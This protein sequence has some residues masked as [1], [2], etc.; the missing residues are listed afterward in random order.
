MSR[1]YRLALSRRGR[2]LRH[3][4]GKLAGQVRPSWRGW[5]HAGAFPLAVLGGLAMSWNLDTPAGPSIVVSAA[6]LFMLALLVPRK[7]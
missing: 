1:S 7:A 5:I 6:G 4:L 3:E 2:A